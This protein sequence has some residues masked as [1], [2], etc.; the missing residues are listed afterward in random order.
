MN[1]MMSS[2]YEVMDMAEPLARDAMHWSWM[3][4]QTTI[5]PQA[6]KAATTAWPYVSAANEWGMKHLDSV[7]RWAWTQ[8]THP[9]SG[10]RSMYMLQ[11]ILLAYIL[12][13]SYNV[14]M[15]I[16]RIWLQPKP[17]PATNGKTTSWENA[18]RRPVTRSQ[19][20]AAKFE[21]QR[22]RQ[23]RHEFAHGIYQ[24]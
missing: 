16:D 18:P 5:Q 9:Q 19:V 4:W 17:Q 6:S 23:D 21:S 8:M 3:T 13:S 12:W 20:K 14:V 10:E 22:R 1:T 15:A 24:P 2:V 11:F 7:M